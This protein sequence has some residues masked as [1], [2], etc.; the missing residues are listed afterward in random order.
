MA[1]QEISKRHALYVIGPSSTGKTT[2]C[3]ALAK[4]LRLS[5]TAHVTEVARTV[6]QE[7]GYTRNDVH[8]LEMQ[9]DIMLAHI[10]K[11]RFSRQESPG[12]V[13]CD[14]SAIDPIVYVV[15]TATDEQMAVERR[16]QLV[17]MDE[18]QHI[19]PLYRESL[20]VV[21]GPVEEWVVDD[22]VRSIENLQACYKTFQ[23]TLDYLGIK[24]QTLGME[25]KSLA[26][27]VATVKMVGFLCSSLL[28]V[29][30]S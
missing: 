26:E 22:G 30:E 25:T 11:E 18:F 14:R 6:L 21:L 23:A 2:L 13:L 10:Q 12:L 17:Q 3:N 20:F 28:P 7:R 8:N 19:L 24:Y 15:L 5:Q 16:D 29:S 4:D 9:R 27:R 1:N